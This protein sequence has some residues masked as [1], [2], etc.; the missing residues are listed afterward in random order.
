MGNSPEIVS[1]ERIWSEAPHSGFSDLTRFG[2]RW[3]CAFREGSSRDSADGAIRVLSSSDG[4]HWESAFVYAREGADLRDPKLTVTPENHLMLTATSI[5]ESAAAKTYQTLSWYATDGRNWGAPYKIIGPNVLLWRIGWHLGNAFGMGYST[6]D[7]RY[8]SLYTGPGGL[9]FRPIAERIH[10]EDTPTEATLLFNR[11][12]TAYCLLRRDGGP[13]TTMLGVAR[14]PYRG[15]DWYDLGVRLT[16]PNMLRLPDGRIVAAGGAGTQGART[17]LYWL[18]EEKHSLEDLTMLPS[19]GDTGHP[20]LAFEDDLLWVSYHS[21]H[22]G[23]A[24]IYL[25][26]V[27]LP[28]PK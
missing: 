4:A 11:D 17:S 13:G 1:I 23:E 21:S 10:E 3:Y 12:D 19:G 26:K 27:R 28:A 20:G 16:A 6:T 8:V 25:A 5:D 22:S 7:D 9:R 14:P 24:A 15:W 2:G 18:D